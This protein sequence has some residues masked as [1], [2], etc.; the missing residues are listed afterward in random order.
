MQ[1]VKK[2][3]NTLKVAKLDINKLFRLK[4]RFLI[5][6]VLVLLVSLYQEFVPMA[7]LIVVIICTY[8]I[9]SSDMLKQEH[10]FYASLP[11][12]RNDV[13]R[14]RYTFI[15]LMIVIFAA[16]MGVMSTIGSIT[17]DADYPTLYLVSIVGL[18]FLCSLILTGIMLPMSFYMDVKKR[19]NKNIITLVSLGGFILASFYLPKLNDI[20][21][22][23]NNYLF[24]Y[25]SYIAGI[26]VYIVSYIASLGIY[27]KREFLEEK[28][29]TKK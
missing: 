7:H 21:M 13:V 9:L 17:M 11:I 19:A 5:M 12:S 18:S 3:I 16:I 28:I 2:L 29:E 27:R 20:I 4:K 8:A 23:S 15:F 26:V 22:E 10:Y 14:G 1:G 6:L 25:G 24:V